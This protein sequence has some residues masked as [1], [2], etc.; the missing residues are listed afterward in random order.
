MLL[1]WLPLQEIPGCQDPISQSVRVLMILVDILVVFMLK[2]G[3]LPEVSGLRD[4]DIY[5]YPG[6]LCCWLYLEMGLLNFLHFV[7]KDTT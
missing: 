7:R 6:G 3:Q 1:T 5:P 4:G 2:T